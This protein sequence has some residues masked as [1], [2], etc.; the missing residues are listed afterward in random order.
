M[1][2]RASGLDVVLDVMLSVQSEKV[3]PCDLQKLTRSLW[4]SYPGWEM[5]LRWIASAAA[6]QSGEEKYVLASTIIFPQVH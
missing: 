1:V 5:V 3:R 6:S 4:Y 2:G